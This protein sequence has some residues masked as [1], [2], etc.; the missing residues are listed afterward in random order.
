MGPSQDG[1]TPRIPPLPILGA[2][3]VH[4]RAYCAYTGVYHS[5]CRVLYMMV[6]ETLRFTKKRV[7]RF[8]RRLYT[9][10]SQTGI[11]EYTYLGPT[12]PDQGC[13]GGP[14]V[15]HYVPR[16]GLAWGPLPGDPLNG[17]LSEHPWN[18]G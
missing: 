4:G 7:C 2:Y 5:T 11:L 16:M 10:Y 9:L 1:A 15:P 3:G 18:T 12:S 13:W 17:A 8:P 6:L 14:R